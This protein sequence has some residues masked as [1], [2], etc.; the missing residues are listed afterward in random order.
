[1]AFWGHFGWHFG[2]F[3][4]GTSVVLWLALGCH[5]GCHLGVTLGG[6]S[7]ARWVALYGGTLV[8][9]LGGAFGTFCLALRGLFLV[10][11]FPF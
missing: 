7:L 5:F 8:G 4:G 3:L 1:M 9:S 2:G 11:K 10:G 6:T